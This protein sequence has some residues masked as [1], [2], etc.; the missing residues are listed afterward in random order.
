MLLRYAVL[1]CTLISLVQLNA[2]NCRD[3]TDVQF[4][5]DTCYIGKY[6][7]NLNI[8]IL[9]LSRGLNVRLYNQ[10]N[11]NQFLNYSPN[12][13]ANLGFGICY[14]W[15]SMEAAFRSPFDKGNAKK[16]QTKQFSLRVNIIRQRFWT[17]LMIVNYRGFYL[18]NPDLIDKKWFDYNQNY[19]QRPDM[20]THT[21]YWVGNY[22]F[23]HK[24]FSVMASVNNFER[25][26]K[27]AGTLVIGAAFTS[28]GFRADSSFMPRK[29]DQEFDKNAPL[30]GINTTLLAFNIGYM[31]TF[32]LKKKYFAHFA[33]IPSI[34]IKSTLYDSEKTPALASE[35]GVGVAADTRISFGYNS[36]KAFGG[37]GFHNIALNSSTNGKKY[38]DYGY[39]SVKV[40]YGRRIKISNYKKI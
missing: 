11:L 39:V 9:T 4:K 14:K 2:Y 12:N 36:Q 16:G 35:G 22:V 31:H 1:I 21:F 15:L 25:Q 28:Y 34:G 24:K 40:F 10:A 8:S 5:Y 18:T 26:K 17:S 3:T 32:V 6:R 30:K 20:V 13:L 19:P 33:L 38:V 37:I 23:N 29:L 27:S 7:N